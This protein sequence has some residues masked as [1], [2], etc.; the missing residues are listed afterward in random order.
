[1]EMIRSLDN[2]VYHYDNASNSW[3]GAVGWLRDTYNWLGDTYNCTMESSNANLKFNEKP[4]KEP[5][6]RFTLAFPEIDKVIF[7][8]PATVI[9]FKDGT[10][11]IVKCSEHDEYDQEKGFA[12]ALLKHVLGNK[13]YKTLFKKYVKKA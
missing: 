11:S 12:M 2:T 6:K 3:Y 1:M 9:I 13:K 5:I 7:H 4:P 8:A 10:K